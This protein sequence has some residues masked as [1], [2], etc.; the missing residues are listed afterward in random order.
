MCLLKQTI[1]IHPFLKISQTIICFFGGT[2]VYS[3][4]VFFNFC[5]SY[6]K[7]EM[8]KIDSIIGL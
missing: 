4:L 8:F 3:I 5:M 1:D 6:N 2:N 7:M